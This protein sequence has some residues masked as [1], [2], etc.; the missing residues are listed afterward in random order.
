MTSITGTA[1]AELHAT[2]LAGKKH[3][4][5]AVLLTYDIPLPNE[6]LL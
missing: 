6:M 1:L 2:D 4:L 5:F 3:I